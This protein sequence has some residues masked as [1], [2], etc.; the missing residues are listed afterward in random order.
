MSISRPE[1]HRFASRRDA[2]LAVIDLPVHR[3][4]A[5]GLPGH[6]EHTPFYQG[7]H[8]TL[9]DVGLCLHGFRLAGHD[10]RRGYGGHSDVAPL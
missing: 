1:P 4:A 9:A 8:K 2:T 3:L 7:V 6:V 5:Y 10:H